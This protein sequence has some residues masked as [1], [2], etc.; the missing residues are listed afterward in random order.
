MVPPHGAIT[1]WAALRW[2]GGR[3]FD[4][5]DASGEVR[6]V[7]ILISTH[8]IRRQ[9]GIKPCGEGTR[10]EDIV[11]VDDVRVTNAVWSTAFAMRYAGTPR[12]AAL[13]LEMAAYDDLASVNELEVLV[14]AQ[15]GWTGVPVARKGL[16]LAGENAWSP[17]EVMMKQSWMGAGFPTPLQNVPIFDLS[18]RHIGTPDLFDPVAGVIGEYDGRHHLQ[19]GQR[20]V[21]VRRAAEFA[22]HLLECVTM[23]AGDTNNQFLVRLGAAYRRARRPGGPRTWTVEP[24]EWWIPTRT[25]A[26]R[27]SLTPEQR[28]RFLRYRTA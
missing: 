20:V 26:Q 27:R 2:L 4:G 3:W 21:D 6:P 16:P 5:T 28:A 22:E 7:D 12:R 17:T 11:V 23:L 8:D 14:A 10:P 25:V 19:S 15:S 9:Q 18:G 1:G 13:V 24:P